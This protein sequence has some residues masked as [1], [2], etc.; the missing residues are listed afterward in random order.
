MLLRERGT[1]AFQSALA[2][3]QNSILT[4]NTTA[5][6]KAMND[7]EGKA[8]W[9]SRDGVIQQVLTNPDGIFTYFNKHGSFMTSLRQ[10]GMAV[11]HMVVVDGKNA[12]GR[13]IIRDPAK[14]TKYLMEWSEYLRVWEGQVV[15]RTLP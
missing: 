13:V 11:S 1:V 14:G 15:W 5:L 12:A 4:S 2:L 3:R 7:L 8:A 10:E 6:S 9:T